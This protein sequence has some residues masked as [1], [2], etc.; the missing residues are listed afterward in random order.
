MLNTITLPD[1]YLVLD[2]EF[3]DDEE[4]YRRYLRIDPRPA[5]QRWPFRKVIAA[6]VMALAV[7]GRSLEVTSFKSFSGPDEDK[8]LL[9]LFAHMTDYGDHRLVTYSGCATDVPILR[10]GACANGLK[11][12]PQLIGNPRKRGEFEHLDLAIIFKGGAGQYCH[13]SEIAVRC[14]VPV[15]MG[16]TAMAIPDLVRTGNYRPIEWLAEADTISTACVLASYLGTHINVSLAPV[17]A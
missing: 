11:L 10:A 4:L 6:N 14:N 8:V 13:L 16:G 17:E 1:R 15:K 7:D 2:I 9:N 12:P 5:Q 3:V